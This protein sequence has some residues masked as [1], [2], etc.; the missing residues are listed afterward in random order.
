[1]GR[2][3]FDLPDAEIELDYDV[4][5][6]YEPRRSAPG[7]DEIHL[8]RIIIAYA[9]LRR[10]SRPRSWMGERKTPQETHQRTPLYKDT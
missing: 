6:N 2:V 4:H 7:S 3:K 1:M 10:D 5:G 8:G 9:V